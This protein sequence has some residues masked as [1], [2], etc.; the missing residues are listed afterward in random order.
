MDQAG[1]E[2]NA[3][4]TVRSGVPCGEE[5]PAFGEACCAEGKVPASGQ[6]CS[7]E[8]EVPALEQAC[9]TE[10]KVLDSVY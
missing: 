10:R 6:T 2:G 4:D 5:V 7:A 3:L 8:G 9:S 1:I